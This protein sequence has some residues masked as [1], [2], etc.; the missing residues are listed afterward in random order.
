LTVFRPI[1]ARQAA[2]LIEAAGIPDARRL[3]IDSAAA[4]L[5]KA[6]ALVMETIKRPGVPK[7]DRGSTIPVHVLRRVVSQGAAD[8]LWSGGTVHLPGSDLIGG[9][10]EINLTTVSFNEKHLR[11]LI[12][13]HGGGSADAHAR[14]PVRPMQPALSHDEVLADAEVLIGVPEPTRVQGRPDPSAI[15]LGALTVTM[16]QAMAATGLGRTTVDKLCNT[17]KLTRVKVGGRALITTESI[18]NLLE[19]VT[20]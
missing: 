15:P 13:H 11:R 19:P 18:R 8:D 14:V 10:P 6:Y 7:V 2:E 17:G 20:D 5:V 1:L 12:N 9:A 3:L 16:K 4:D